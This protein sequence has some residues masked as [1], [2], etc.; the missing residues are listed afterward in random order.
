MSS[1]TAVE[2]KSNRS[3]NRCRSRQRWNRT[4]GWWSSRK[5]G[6]QCHLLLDAGELSLAAETGRDEARG[7]ALMLRLGG[8]RLAGGDECAAHAERAGAEEIGRRKAC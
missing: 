8:R 3:C 7:A 1:R 4:D 5:G 6:L 2:S